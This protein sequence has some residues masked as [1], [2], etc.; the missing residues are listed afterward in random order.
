MISPATNLLAEPDDKTFPRKNFA[1]G[2]PT[3][4]VETTALPGRFPKIRIALTFSFL[5]ACALGSACLAATD[6]RPGQISV[7]S[8]EYCS[9]VKG[10]TTV[11][12]LAPGFKNAKVKCWK[13]G[14]G[15][16]ADSTV[17]TLALDTNGA[18]SFVF[19]ADVY[20]HGPI[21]VRISAESGSLKDNCYLQL[22]NKG[23]VS[24]NEGLPP[25][26]PAAKGM[27]LLFAD[28]FNGPLSISSTNPKATYYDHKPPDGSQDFSAH[29]FCGYASARNPF[30]QIDTYLRIRAN[31]RTHSAGLISS[32]KRD[33]SGLTAKA[34][35][36]F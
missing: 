23:G 13:Q 34:P 17:A 26:P 5:F 15:F 10:D 9:E 11:A 1:G 30:F 20:P 19:P 31:D 35:C 24:W 12:V 21:T 36:Y 7:V 18:G 16:G 14:P 2:T 33:D 29:T 32:L 22:Y 28:D 3:K 6:T 25:D 27:K 8:P 4:G